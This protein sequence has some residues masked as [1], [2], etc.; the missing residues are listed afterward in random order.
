MARVYPFSSSF[1]PVSTKFPPPALCAS[2]GPL[3]LNSARRGRTRRGR[4]RRLQRGKRRN[5]FAPHRR[6]LLVFPVLLFLLGGHT[7]L[8]VASL[9]S[10]FQR[11]QAR[12]A[13]S[14]QLSRLFCCVASSGGLSP[15]FNSKVEMTTSE[16]TL[17]RRGRLSSYFVVL[18]DLAH[19]LLEA[20]VSFLRGL[21]EQLSR[22]FGTVQV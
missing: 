11:A 22:E 7:V 16:A 1:R 10:R 6:L 3:F 8:A 21:E 5:N 2:S 14:L 18:L 17:C 12:R 19:V 15:P 13:R 9:I 4:P 20:L